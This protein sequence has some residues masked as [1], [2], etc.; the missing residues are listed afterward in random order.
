MEQV[1]LKLQNSQQQ[2]RLLADNA[3]VLSHPFL[4]NMFDQAYL[5]AP[6]P[7]NILG[8]IPE[9]GSLME[10]MLP[11]C[12]ELLGRILYG[13]KL[14]LP[15]SILVPMCL[16]QQHQETSFAAHPGSV[17]TGDH[18]DKGSDWKDM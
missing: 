1:V 16:I 5:P 4:S 15:D 13:G 10:I 18:L 3:P 14:Y 17:K 7:D 9:N 6:L 8:A 11:D 2:L 12:T